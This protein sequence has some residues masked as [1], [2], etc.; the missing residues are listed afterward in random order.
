MFRVGVL[1]TFCSPNRNVARLVRS[2]SE[3]A[4]W[5]RCDADVT[6]GAA[7]HRRLRIRARLVARTGLLAGSFAC[8]FVEH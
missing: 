5:R 6:P 7:A 1:L 2:R 8:V 4:R 3:R